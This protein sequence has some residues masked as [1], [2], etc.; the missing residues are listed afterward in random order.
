V[1][2]STFAA[3]CAAPRTGSDPLTGQPYADR[4]GT[5]LAENNWLR[6]WS[7]D[8]YLWSDEIVDLDPGL[9]QTAAYFN[10]LKTSQLNPSGTPKD[11][12]HFTYRTSDWIA[13][14]QSG[15]TASYG[16]VWSIQA[17]S[18]PQ[19]LVAYTE[20]GSP[21]TQSGT[22]L[23]R[24]D[25][26]LTVDGVD[27]LFPTSQG[28]VDKIMAGLYPV[29]TGET[30]VF[31]V[32]SPRQGTTSDITLRSADVAITP[33]KNVQVF[34]TTA[35]PVGYAL[36]TDHI[37][38]SEQ[39]L[40]DA[41]TMFSNAHI[42][43]LVLDIRY[44]GGGY[45]AIAGE[46]AYMIA[47]AVPTAGQTFERLTFN[48]KH[49]SVDPVTGDPLTPLPFPTTTLGFS[50]ASG[51]PLPTVNLPRVFVLTGPTTC[52]ASESIINSL[53]GVNV[54]V[55]Q[56]GSTTCGKPYGFYPADNC[57]TTYFTIQFKGVN[58]AGFGDYSDGFAPSNSAS[59]STARL[60][61]CQVRDDFD[62][63]LGDP[64]EQRLQT[65][66]TYRQTRSCPAPSTVGPLSVAPSRAAQDAIDG[67]VRKSPWLENR[68]LK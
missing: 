23:F 56:I 67:V 58:A 47:G 26:V 39:A 22:Q 14:S 1:P 43:D 37:A 61:G 8:L 29:S 3:Q 5:V 35:G 40:F 42:S 20:P 46:V 15:V 13:L 24:G 21:A 19:I 7:N 50:G 51:R 32:S 66:M 68:T 63:D 62:H 27:A 12:F 30:H 18:P 53:R 44:N 9:Y 2:E 28:D 45:L 6:S 55:I 48:A 34:D 25:R 31:K 10:L 11:K 49:P 16:A 4:Q 17:T 59:S 54:E 60:T 65:A 52:S 64:S 38:T 41:F 57:G 33:V 36:F